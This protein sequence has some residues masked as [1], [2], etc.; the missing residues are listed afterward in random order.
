MWMLGVVP[1][2]KQPVLLA[3]ELLLQPHLDIFTFNQRL[4]QEL[5]FI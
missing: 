5:P 1:L 2:G 4:P 3:A